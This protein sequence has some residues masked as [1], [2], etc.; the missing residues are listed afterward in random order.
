MY[1][2]KIIA[3]VSITLIAFNATIITLFFLFTPNIFP[4]WF[5]I[6]WTSLFAV[7]MWLI[8]SFRRFSFQTRTI[9]A[10]IALLIWGS[11]F[12]LW[13]W[14]HTTLQISSP[15]KYPWFLW[16]TFTYGLF[17]LFFFSPGRLKRKKRGASPLVR[18]MTGASQSL[19][20]MRV[21]ATPRFSTKEVLPQKVERKEPPATQTI[22]GK[23]VRSP[24]PIPTAF[25]EKM[26]P[27]T[28]KIK[29][30]PSPRPSS[31]PL[32]S[33]IPIPK[34]PKPLPQ[35]SLGTKIFAPEPIRLTLP[36]RAPPRFMKGRAVEEEK[37]VVGEK[38]ESRDVVVDIE[39]EDEALSPSRM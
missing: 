6:L 37:K 14:I 9:M 18:E 8:Y 7:I 27:K 20:Y 1:S 34:T 15:K 23:Y 29:E 3:T 22:K 39:E 10:N 12:L 24:Q 21:I 38:K 25:L 30:L 26:T 16:F 35:A 28:T 32:P 11:I 13:I 17:L 36:P 2:L 33:A 31:A 4:W 5:L 19:N